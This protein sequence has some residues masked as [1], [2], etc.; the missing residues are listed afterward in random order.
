MA[1]HSFNRLKKCAHRAYYVEYDIRLV[2]SFFFLVLD[3]N[4]EKETVSD[5]PYKC[6]LN[7]E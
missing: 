6:N 1:L 5:I 2:V 3:C 7:G 4:R